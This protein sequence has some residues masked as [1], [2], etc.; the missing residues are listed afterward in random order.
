MG[1]TR[2]FASIE[3]R[4]KQKKPHGES[5]FPAEANFHSEVWFNTAPNIGSSLPRGGSSG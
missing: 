3:P 1:L 2:R 5:S 4:K